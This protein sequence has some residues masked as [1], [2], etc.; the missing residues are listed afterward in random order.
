M[1]TL[2]SPLWT[3][4]TVQ[5]AF[6]LITTIQLIRGVQL[7]S[8]Q[9]VEETPIDTTV[10]NNAND[11]VDDS[12][13]KMFV[14]CPKIK[15]HVEAISSSIITML[16]LA[17]VVHLLTVDVKAMAIDSVHK[18]NVRIFVLLTKRKNHHHQ[19]MRQ[20]MVSYCRLTSVKFD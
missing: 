12:V 18:R 2:A 17:V 7:S 5:K 15:D 10:K 13:A 3:L 4:A 11:N 8:T 9:A 16:H 19:P 6:Q 20:L 14:V 1:P